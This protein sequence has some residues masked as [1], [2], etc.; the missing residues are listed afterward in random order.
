MSAVY[1]ARGLT[2]STRTATTCTAQHGKA[3]VC[4]IDQQPKTSACI[5]PGGCNTTS[6]CEPLTSC[7]TYVPCAVVYV[8]VSCAEERG[9]AVNEVV[10]HRP[11]H[12]VKTAQIM[13][14]WDRVVLDHNQCCSTFPVGF[15]VL[16]SIIYA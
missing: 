11:A 4:A 12:T 8:L 3:Y 16:L 15:A 5:M 10:L 14:S 6:C 13:I 2:H 9:I 7:T 1:N